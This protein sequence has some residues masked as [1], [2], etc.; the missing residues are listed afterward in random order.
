MYTFFT[1]EKKPLF[2][3]VNHRVT[4]ASVLL[5]KQEELFSH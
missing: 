3:T 2:P 5:I 4:D 1:V